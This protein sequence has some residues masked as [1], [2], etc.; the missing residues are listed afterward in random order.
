M[1][2]LGG[3]RGAETQPRRQEL[4]DRLV[5][6]KIGQPFPESVVRYELRKELNGLRL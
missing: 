4:I 2:F 1:I 5:S 6:E 3:S